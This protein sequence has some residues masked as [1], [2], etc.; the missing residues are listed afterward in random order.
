[1]NNVAYTEMMEFG[2]YVHS[3]LPARQRKTFER[4]LEELGWSSINPLQIKFIYMLNL[5]HE[6][7]I[8]ARLTNAPAELFDT[9]LNLQDTLENAVDEALFEVDVTQF[10]LS[11]SVDNLIQCKKLYGKTP[12]AVLNAAFDGLSLNSSYEYYAVLLVRILSDHQN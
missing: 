6:Q 7:L 4:R 12:A 9:I 1:M 10:P 2:T 3:K 11:T 5:L 8:L